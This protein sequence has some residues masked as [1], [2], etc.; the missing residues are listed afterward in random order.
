VT[1]FGALEWN[2]AGIRQGGQSFNSIDTIVLV[3]ESRAPGGVPIDSIG[4]FGDYAVVATTNVIRLWYKNRTGDWV[5]VGSPEWTESWPTVRSVSLPANITSGSIKIGLNSATAPEISF[6][7]GSLGDLVNAI[8][9]V[10]DPLN[11]GISAGAV[12]GFLEIYSDENPVYVSSGGAGTLFN[13]LGIE[14]GMYQPP[15]VASC[16]SYPSSRIQDQ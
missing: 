7:G 10:L 14:A 12:D 16:S 13:A 1:S 11:I 9:S 6:G 15:T 5:L 8:N 4:T 2:S 3:Q